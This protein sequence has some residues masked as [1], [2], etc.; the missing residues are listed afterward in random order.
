MANTFKELRIWKK[1]YK[2]LMT[3]YDLT[4]KYPP[5]EKFNLVSQTR[6]SANSVIANIAEAQGRYYYAD[7]VRVLYVGRGECSETQSHLVVAYGRK[8]IKKKVYQELDE[9]YEGLSRG[10]NSYIIRLK[11]DKE[12]D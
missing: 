11:R 4:E 3:I 1:G 5:S 10:I 2:L 12:F 8:Y 9:E 6:R 7:K